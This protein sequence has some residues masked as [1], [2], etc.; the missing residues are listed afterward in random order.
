MMEWLRSR[1]DWVIT[2][3]IV[4]NGIRG[5]LSAFP[6]PLTWD[7]AAYVNLANDFYYFGFICYQPLQVL[8]DFARVPLLTYIIYLAYLITTP[9]IIVAQI[10]TYL[11]SLAGIYAV[12]LLG[13]EIYSKTVGKFSAL[14]LS[15]GLTFFV[16]F[17]GVL[18]EVPYIVFSSLFLLFIIRAQKNPKYYMPAGVSLTLCFLSRYPGA[19]ILLVGLAFIFLSKNVKKTLKSPW[20]YLGIIFAFL[21]VL[22]WLY[23]SKINTGEWLGLLRTFFA[24]TQT[25]NR[26]LYVNPFAPPNPLQIISFYLESAVYAVIPIFT[27]AFLF[28]YFYIAS[29]TEKSSIGGKTLLFW[30]L[31]NILVYFLLMP[32]SR[33]VDFFRYNQTSLPAFC[34]LIG[35]GLAILL[36]EEFRDRKNVINTVGRSILKNKKNIALLLLILNISGGFIGVFMVR[37]NPEVAQPLPVYDYLKYTSYPWQIILTN[38]YPMATHYTDRLCI[39]IPDIPSWLD[40]WAQSGHVRAIFVS[41]FNYVP[42]TTLI[43]LQTSPL[44]EPELVLY[45]NGF[46]CM[47]VYRV[48]P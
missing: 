4:V 35:F 8:L 12:Y 41:L 37:T 19:L 26:M 43:H 9:N 31:S 17:W 38:V 5:I 16:I 46:P 25:W 15:C 18:S 6:V 30:I 48:V 42:V 7:E 44:Y 2:I 40:A 22:P 23:F 24:S 3:I 39:W 20:F 11:I 36:T 21:T 28:P 29:K 27:P 45:Q 32:N 34:V 10:L 1:L 47:I 14:A 33:L 13:K